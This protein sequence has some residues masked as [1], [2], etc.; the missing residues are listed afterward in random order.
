ME[1]QNKHS[2]PPTRHITFFDIPP[3]LAP[4]RV[5]VV[6]LHVTTFRLKLFEN[7][8][9]ALI[10]SPSFGGAL[11]GGSTRSINSPCGIAFTIV[12]TST[13]SG[14]LSLAGTY[15]CNGSRSMG[16]Y[17][18]DRDPGRELGVRVV[19]ESRNDEGG[20]FPAT[21]CR[22]DVRSPLFPVPP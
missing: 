18:P 1:E 9:D 19:D 20:S 12:A 17:D 13:S 2:P 7:A 15:R 11:S 22:A 21:L 6:S 8:Y 10:S 14:S 16:V 3:P 4:E 5:R